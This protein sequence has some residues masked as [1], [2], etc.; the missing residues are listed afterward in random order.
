MDVSVFSDIRKCI[1]SSRA[2]PSVCGEQP[3]ALIIAWGQLCTALASLPLLVSEAR[4]INMVGNNGWQA[5][6]TAMSPNSSSRPDIILTLGG[7]QATPLSPLHSSFT[8]SAMPL[9]TDH[10]PACLSVC[11]SPSPS[12]TTPYH[13]SAHSYH[14]HLAGAARCQVGPCFLLGAR[15]RQLQA[16]V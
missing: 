5:R 14:A 7:N 13:T 16:C 3:V 1:F 15:G 11:L 8:S 6:N 12:L 4:D 9:S 2:S 10:E